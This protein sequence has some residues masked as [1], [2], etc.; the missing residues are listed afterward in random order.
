L[1]TVLIVVLTLYV[2]LLYLVACALIVRDLAEAKGYRTDALTLLLGLVFGVFA[3]L[4]VHLARPRS[5]R[6][7]IE[8]A[9]ILA[10]RR[11]RLLATMATLSKYGF[12]IGCGVLILALIAEHL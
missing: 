4:F 6:S 12:W 10:D 1:P 9:R 7:P 3:V 11:P 5:G 2:A 8:I